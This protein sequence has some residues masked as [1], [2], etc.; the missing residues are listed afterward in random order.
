[1]TQNGHVR[2]PDGAHLYYELHG[3]AEPTC[4]VPAACFLSLDWQSLTQS[5]R[6]IFFDQRNRGNSIHADGGRS[7][8]GLDYE[9]TDIDAIRQH[10][11]LETFVLIGWSYLGA[12]SALYAAR[13]PQHVSKLIMIGAIP[14]RAYRHYENDPAYQAVKQ[15]SAARVDEAGRAYLEMLRGEG[16]HESDPVRFCH[17]YRKVHRPANMY[18]LDG[19]TRMQN[20]PCQYPNEHP[21]RVAENFKALY[22]DFGDWD[23]RS[24][25]QKITCPTLLIHGEE[26]R[27]PLAGAIEWAAHSPQSTLHRIPECAHFPW[28]EAPDIFFDLLENFLIE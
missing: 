7:I 17:E 9:L 13:Y 8:V 4:I 5:R 18:N 22:A 11:A 6:V 3:D 20:D 27:V 10:F 1:M 2:T 26:D 23:W 21:D 14:P 12:M 16:I 24:H 28:L 25:A 15:R 19:L